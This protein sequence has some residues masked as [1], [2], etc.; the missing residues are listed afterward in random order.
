VALSRRPEVSTHMEEWIKDRSDL[1]IPGS[2][3]R[4]NPVI[5]LSTFLDRL[6]T[7]YLESGEGSGPAPLYSM[8]P[9]L[10]SVANM[11]SSVSS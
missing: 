5:P 9:A 8:A 11:L 7:M 1:L 4:P 6:A 10:R 3:D 2:V